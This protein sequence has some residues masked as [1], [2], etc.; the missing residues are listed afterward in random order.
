MRLN[1]IFKET[2]R[3]LYGVAP[4]Y[5]SVTRSN[6]ID[7]MGAPLYSDSKEAVMSLYGRILCIIMTETVGLGGYCWK[8][9]AFYD[10][11]YFAIAV[12][13]ENK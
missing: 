1:D 7:Y 2:V 12:L 8:S 4:L 6:L 11:G 5:D 13:L 9:I 10:M 3:R